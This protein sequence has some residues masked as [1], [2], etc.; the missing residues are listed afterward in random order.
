MSPIFNGFCDGSAP[1]CHF[2]VNGT[3]YIYGYYLVDGIYPEF[4]VFVKTLTCPG[5]PKCIKYKTYQEKARKDVERAFGVLKK[6]WRILQ[7]PTC[8]RSVEKLACIMYACI[9][10]HNMIL[11]DEHKIIC[12]FQ[13]KDGASSSTLIP[14]GSILWRA[15]RRP[16]CDNQKHHELRNDLTEHIYRV[17]EIDLNEPMDNDIGE[18]SD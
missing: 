13:P 1:S 3:T 12:Q 14:P 15:R 5:D 17:N 2:Q 10:L 4:V 18:Y 16:I 8:P 11:K 6:C 9:I 7:H